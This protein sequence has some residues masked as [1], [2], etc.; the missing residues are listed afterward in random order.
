M[1]L[2]RLKF[3]AV[4]NLHTINHLSAIHLKQSDWEMVGV[5]D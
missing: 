3:R 2:K 4:K 1:L 5:V